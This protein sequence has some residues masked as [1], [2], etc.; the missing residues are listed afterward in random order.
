ML[1]I[2]VEAVEL[3]SSDTWSI[4]NDFRADISM[5]IIMKMYLTQDVCNSNFHWLIT[6]IRSADDDDDDP[7]SNNKSTIDCPGVPVVWRYEWWDWRFVSQL[8]LAFVT[9]PE[10]R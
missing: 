2:P 7:Q 5:F 9:V 4:V 3:I 8:G 10:E 1:K 6:H